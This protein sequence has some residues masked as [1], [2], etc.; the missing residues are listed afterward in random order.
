MP[1]NIP[2]TETGGALEPVLADRE[3]EGPGIVG[4]GAGSIACLELKVVRGLKFDPEGLEDSATFLELSRGGITV[5]EAQFRG[6]NGMEERGNP[7]DVN[8]GG[9]RFRRLNKI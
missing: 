9:E 1:G 3:L 2:G 5:V 4:E 6:R 8:M 7:Q